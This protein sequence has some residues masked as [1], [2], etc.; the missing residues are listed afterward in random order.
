MRGA[1]RRAALPLPRTARPGHEPSGAGTAR[2]DGLARAVA[3]PAAGCGAGCGVRTAARTHG[4]RHRHLLDYAAVRLFVERARAAEA[5]F[6]LTPRNAPAIVQVCRRLDGIP[7]AIEL[8]AARVR[9]LSVEEIGARLRDGFGLLTGGGRA[10]LPRQQTLAATFDWSW[11]LLSAGGADPAAPPVRVRRR[12]DA[13]SGGGR[14]AA[15][16]DFGFW[17]LDCRQRRME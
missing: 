15:I 12:L 7:L 6:A 17:I 14:S 13:G 16:L 8:A 11:D 1:G 4:S 2:R 3:V 10:L 9:S 5:A